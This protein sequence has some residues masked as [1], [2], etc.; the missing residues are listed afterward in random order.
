MILLEFIARWFCVVWRIV[1]GLFVWLITARDCDHCEYQ[2]G[3][4]CS[5]CGYACGWTECAES[6]LR[7]DFKRRT[8]WIL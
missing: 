7:K 5:K 6:V 1:A 8:W 3:D 2:E 4:M